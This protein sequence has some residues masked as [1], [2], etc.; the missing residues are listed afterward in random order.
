MRSADEAG[1]EAFVRHYFVLVNYAQATGDLEPLR[2]VS[3][4]G[5]SACRGGI[6][7]L[8]RLARKGQTVIGGDYS[9]ARVRSVEGLG[10]GRFALRL[11]VDSTPQRVL[12]SAGDE[13]RRH[14]GAQTDVVLGVQAPGESGGAWRVTRWSFV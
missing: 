13:V 7:S 14:A 1:A 8:E 6:E 5:C 11:V 12:N 9:V 4:A 2:A 10:G 3:G